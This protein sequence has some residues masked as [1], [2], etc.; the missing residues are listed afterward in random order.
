MFYIDPGAIIHLRWSFFYILDKTWRVPRV[1]SE[2]SFFDQGR[3]AIIEIYIL[4]CLIYGSF[5]FLHGRAVSR[6]LNYVWWCRFWIL[7]EWR[8]TLVNLVAVAMR[9][10]PRFCRQLYYGHTCLIPPLLCL[11][12]FLPILTSDFYACFL[13]PIFTSDFANSFVMVTPAWSLL[14][15]L[16]WLFLPIFCFRWRKSRQK[17]LWPYLPILTFDGGNICHLTEKGTK[18]L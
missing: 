15:L 14:S 16:L 7:C 18:F 2:F 5:G 13:H 3:S 17:C 6:Q 12:P 8:K 11:R 9:A 4:I 10:F 1:F